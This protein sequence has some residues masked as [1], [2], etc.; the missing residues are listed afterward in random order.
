MPTSPTLEQDTPIM[1]LPY[2]MPLAIFSS[3]GRVHGVARLG[4]TPSHPPWRCAQPQKALRA[5]SNRIKTTGGKPK[6]ILI[7]NSSVKWIN[8]DREFQHV[9]H[10]SEIQ[11]SNSP[12]WFFPRTRFVKQDLRGCKK[13]RGKTRGNVAEAA[14]AARAGILHSLFACANRPQHGYPRRGRSCPYK[15]RGRHVLRRAL[16]SKFVT[17][18]IRVAA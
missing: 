16:S 11:F 8:I 5:E 1:V 18:W 12:G 14:Q 6:D 7:W 2:P 4:V 15:G 10:N 17:I 13:W 9:A 3:V